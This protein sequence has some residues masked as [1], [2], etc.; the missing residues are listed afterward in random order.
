MEMVIAFFKRHTFGLLI[1]FQ[2]GIIL[3]AVSAGELPVFPPVNRLISLDLGYSLTGFTNS[4][5]GIGANY[6]RALL[7]FLSVK[8]GIGHMTFQTDIDD[9]YCTSV[10][11][12][13]FAHY[14]PLA[15]GLD[16]SYIGLGCSADFM[17]YFGDGALPD[18]PADTL[19]SI[20]PVTGWKWYVLRP[21]MIDIHA[22]YKFVIPG[23][24]NY[25]KIK[26]YVNAGVQFGIGFK[27]LLAEQ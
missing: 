18:N 20:I 2:Y 22:G 23:A 10:T 13:L 1:F 21:L 5:W 14:Y 11:V 9:V 26:E 17:H 27:I 15:G 8:G 25:A 24:E 6:E 4:G 12:S 7:R 16:K 19:I 3:G